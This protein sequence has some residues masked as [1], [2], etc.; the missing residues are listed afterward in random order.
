VAR[1]R[2]SS[3]AGAERERIDAVGTLLTQ[4]GSALF[5][6]GP[7]LSIDSGLSHTA[8]FPAWLAGL[9]MMRG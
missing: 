7:G 5:I 8:A 3:R 4:V 1:A 6:T 2:S 9:P